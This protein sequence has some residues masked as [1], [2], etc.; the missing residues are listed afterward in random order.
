MLDS[1]YYDNNVL[2]QWG[3]QVMGNYTRMQTWLQ[4]GG[5]RLVHAS[6]NTQA[7]EWGFVFEA[8]ME[9]MTQGDFLD[10]QELIRAVAGQNVTCATHVSSVASSH[11]WTHKPATQA[12]PV[13]TGTP[14]P[15][16][17]LV[18]VVKGS[19]LEVCTCPEVLAWCISGKLANS[20]EPPSST[21]PRNR[22]RC[23]RHPARSSA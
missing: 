21:A 10:S 22:L 4:D 23:G 16:P 15:T 11:P 9:V 1:I 20:K 13:H 7:E 2:L 6:F 3:V 17:R 18:R 14:Q 5:G 19:R 12:P 8:C